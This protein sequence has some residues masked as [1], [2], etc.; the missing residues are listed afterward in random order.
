MTKHLR[1]IIST[2]VIVVAAIRVGASIPAEPPILNVTPAAPTDSGTTHKGMIASIPF[3]SGHDRIEYVKFYLSYAFWTMMSEPVEDYSFI[4]SWD[5]QTYGRMVVGVPKGW[6]G[7]RS[8]TA[9]DLRK[10]QD[11]FDKFLAIAPTKVE[12]VGEV[13]LYDSPD[14]RSNYASF[15]KNMSVDVPV[16]AGLETPLHSPGSPNWADFFVKDL[17]SMR[18]HYIYGEMFS[19]TAAKAAVTA[20]ERDRSDDRSEIAE[21]NKTSYKYARK[22]RVKI[23]STTPVTMEWPE[24]EFKALA[25]E[26]A[27]REKK[28]KEPDKE[29][30]KN[31]MQAAQNPFAADSPDGGTGK[32]SGAKKANPFAAASGGNGTSL[33]AGA[34]GYSLV[35][36]GLT[37]RDQN[38]NPPRGESPFARDARIIKE[39]TRVLYAVATADLAEAPPRP[40]SGFHLTATHRDPVFNSQA[41]REEYY[42]RQRRAEAKAEERRLRE[43]EEARQR[44]AVR[45]AQRDRLKNDSGAHAIG[46][47]VEI[48]LFVEDATVPLSTDANGAVANF[49][50]IAGSANMGKLNSWNNKGKALEAAFA[51]LRANCGNLDLTTNGGTTYYATR[52]QAL[53]AI[54][55]S[56]RRETTPAPAPGLDPVPA[57][58]P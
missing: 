49:D 43:E 24:Y 14:A 37:L 58:K 12:I 47:A 28:G 5:P 38:P 26:Y 22:L 50:A 7:R 30:V 32:G 44:E 34:S 27:A 8:V 20:S 16:R 1:S 48:S 19:D 52:E 21:L 53:A 54:R 51:S 23:N 41:E 35:Y 33:N 31:A 4:W 45:S 17:P 3:M 18:Q 42:E 36:K 6:E 46:N 29:A 9:E 15:Y 55:A 11:L 39:H 10:Y 2:A 40:V 13:E 57:G 25:E 56:G